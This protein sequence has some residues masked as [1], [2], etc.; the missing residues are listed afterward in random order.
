MMDE[1][2]AAPVIANTRTGAVVADLSQSDEPIAR[3]AHWV[4][5]LMWLMLMS[6]LSIVVVS[7]AAA[8]ILDFI[9]SPNP[10]STGK[11]TILLMHTGSLAAMLALYS[12]RPGTH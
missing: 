1:P 6:V 5:S 11:D 10:P 3:P 4:A 7:T 2:N 9:A 12:N 8:L